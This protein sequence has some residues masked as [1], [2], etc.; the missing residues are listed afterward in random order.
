[1]TTII[2]F[3]RIFNVPTLNKFPKFL[4][5]RN[6]HHQLN[7]YSDNKDHGTVKPCNKNSIIWQPGE[8]GEEEPP[9]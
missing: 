4:Y 8:E 2:E 7:L 5:I 1:V 6:F 3:K 9:A